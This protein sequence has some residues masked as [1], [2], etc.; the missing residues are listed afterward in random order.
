MSSHIFKDIQDK[1]NELK[2]S[3]IRRKGIISNENAGP[4]LSKDSNSRQVQQPQ[5][6]QQQQQQ[7]KFTNKRIPLGGKNHNSNKLLLNRSQSSLNTKPTTQGITN[8]KPPSLPKS[9]SSLGFSVVLDQPTEQ[10]KQLPQ[11]FVVHNEQVLPVKRKLLQDTKDE[12]SQNSK[13]VKLEKKESNANTFTDSLTKPTQN[14]LAHVDDLQTTISSKTDQ[15][16]S[17]NLTHNDINRNNV[18]P[19]KRNLR[20]KAIDDLVESHWQDPIETIPETVGA[21]NNNGEQLEELDIKFFSTPN[22]SFDIGDLDENHLA[23]NE[24]KLSLELDFEDESNVGEIPVIEGI[25]EEIGLTSDDLD[26]LLG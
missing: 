23:N 11:P 5:Q 21:E 3:G 13:R 14:V 2:T 25:D 20:L 26:N 17:S 9:N 7:L 8:V 24:Q 19:V 6:T 15:L 1:E 4:L 22:E 12:L 18:D 10:Q 16:N